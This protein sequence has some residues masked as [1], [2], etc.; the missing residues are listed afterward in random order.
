ML[1]KI[2][3]DVICGPP[4]KERKAVRMH[5]LG[6]LGLLLVHAPS[7]AAIDTWS[8]ASLVGAGGGGGGGFV[9]PGGGFGD[10]F[11]NSF[12]GGGGGGG[13]GGFGGG[14][15]QPTGCDC[16]WAQAGMG[17]ACRQT[18]N[19]ACWD[20]CCTGN[21]QCQWAT[22][23]ASCSPTL[24]D[25][26]PCWS[27]C[28]RKFAGGNVAVG[29][30]GGLGGMG[31]GGLA[32]Q[33]MMMQKTLPA[34]PLAA[35]GPDLRKPLNFRGTR[36]RLYADGRQFTIKGLN[37][38]G[39]EGGNVPPGGLQAHPASWYMQ[40]M[41]SRGFNAIRFLF[42][43]ENMLLDRPL[44]QVA[45]YGAQLLAGASYSQ[46]FLRMAQEAADQH[47]LVMMAA[48]RLRPDAWPGD[49]LWYDGRLTEADVL[50][51]WTKVANTLCTQ[52]NVFAVDLMNEPH[53][54]SWGTGNRA[55][56]W[57]SAAERIGNHILRL[58]PRLLIMVEGVG[59]KPG[60]PGSGQL[61][62]W[63]WGE[64]L[65]GAKTARVTISDMS[66]L[67]YSPH[68]YG[69]SVYMQDYFKSWDF[70]NNM[71]GIWDSHFGFVQQATGAP[72]V[73]GEYG[74]MYDGKDKQW[75]DKFFQYINSK[76]MGSFYFALNPDSDDTGG[77][78]LKDWTTP[79][80]GKLAGLN[81]I[82]ATSVAGLVKNPN[83]RRQLDAGVNETRQE[84]PP[85]PWSR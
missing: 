46:M 80:A 18:D 16:A 14:G 17:A 47:L 19:S 13:G 36:G 35:R 70:P 30:V 58:C 76:Q 25:G 75:Q 44:D 40:F 3:K 60:A 24:N 27:V 78:L 41:A 52:W 82:R 62:G 49:G 63:W 81:T 10:Q 22:S 83:H 32:M 73:I 29:G 54:A 65:W 84:I 38:F 33:Q 64:N 5:L 34:V 28:C 20:F 50:D 1:T 7:A 6:P 48:H 77:I 26:S 12:G 55:T 71:P 31:G 53:A 69:P 23:A 66:K 45:M 79:E 59:Y 74:G 57:N 37:W 43:H 8:G 11:I 72:V 21:C 2:K 68:T 9:S 67:V 51:S 61:Q 85:P 15:A 39:S 56:D 4:C 42:N